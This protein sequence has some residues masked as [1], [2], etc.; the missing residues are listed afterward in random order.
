M[1]VTVLIFAGRLLAPW[2]LDRIV[3]LRDRELFTL[4]VGFFGLGAALVTHTAG[5]SLA[6]G[7]FL[8]GLILSE[9]E[10]GVQ[11]LSDVLPFRAL[12]TGVFF[13]SI[14]MLLDPSVLLGSPLLVIGLGLAALAVKA[15]L[16]AAGVLAAGGRLSTALATGVGLGHV[17]EFAF[18]L[19]AVGI[20][21]GLF[22]GS[23]YQLFLS[24]AVLSMI[25]APLLIR[26]GPAIVEWVDQR[27]P[28]ERH[29]DSEAIHG[30][31]DHTVVVGY[32]LAG[33]YLARVLQ[34]AGLRCIVV[35][36]NPELVRRARA[37]GIPALF[38]DGTQPV[39]LDHVQLRRAR[40]IFFTINSPGDERR[41]V[42]VARELNPAV[43]IVV[44]TRYVRA[45]D[46]LLAIGATDVVVEEFEA[47]L[48]LF[49][50]ALE[51]LRDTDQP[52]LAGTRVRAGRALRPLSRP[53][54]SG[55]AP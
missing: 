5:F 1:I 51:S 12:F 45:I 11:A 25:A 36:Q 8:A 48:E 16:A 46:D 55:S 17:G 3:L 21:L 44:R 43:R 23:D 29:P 24:T 47:S 39:V 41:G 13:S 53:P 50:K 52:H 27:R 20:P 14:G 34:A 54:P 18:L 28:H 40:T 6:I 37:D 49:A 9:S 42:A 30:A 26:A 15:V 10:Y 2:V 4:C 32:G 31:A 7:A 22:R 33:R 38:G 19:A 35:D